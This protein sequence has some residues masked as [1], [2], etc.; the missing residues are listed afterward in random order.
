MQTNSD[1]IE[2]IG[3]LGP[4]ANRRNSL[5]IS[6]GNKKKSKKTK[7]TT[8]ASASNHLGNKKRILKKF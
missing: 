6:T 7:E 4:Q 2:S 5:S 1:D 3:Y 8:N